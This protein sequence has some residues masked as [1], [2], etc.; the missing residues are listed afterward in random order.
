MPARSG[1]AD[2]A[3]LAARAQGLLAAHHANRPLLLPNVWD[4]AS[5]RAVEGAGFDAVATSS[6]A[7]AQVLGETDDDSTDPDL[8]F[9]WVARIARTVSVPVTADL[10]AGY[11]LAPAELVERLLEAGAVG[12]NLEDSD[13]H[14]GGVLVEAERQAAYL[15]GVRAAS[16]AA[17][18]HVVL[19]ARVDAFIRHF[20]DEG[21]QLREAITR[22]R[23]Y[24]E[25]GADCVYPIAVAHNGE[26]AK[27]VDSVPGPLNVMARRGGF[28]ISELATLGVRRISLASGLFQMVG[29]YLREVAGRLAAGVELDDLGA[30]S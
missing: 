26:I 29:E 3:T 17:G 7:V 9:G 24:T 16:E 5:A 21:A 13:H 30:P 25:A 14:G 28:R 12:C 4:A 8:V 18:V 27:L 23:L 11:R 2:V 15:A 10:E 20:G 19:N 6:R 1:G 22:G